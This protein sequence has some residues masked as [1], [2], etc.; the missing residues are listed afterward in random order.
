[1]TRTPLGK[2]IARAL[3]FC[4]ILQGWPLGA[5]P[6]PSRIFRSQG[7]AAAALTVFGPRDYVR[8]TGVPVVESA[9][10]RADPGGSF[11]LAIANGGADGQ[12]QRV[13]SAVI[14]LNGVIVVMPHEF[15]PGVGLIT[16]Q[17]PLEA[18]NTLL[19]E[20][21]GAPGSGLT[22]RI[23]GDASANQRPIASAGSD[24]TVNLGA[25]VQL[26]G[27]GSSD[28]D[29][30]PLTYRWTITS[31]PA[32]S[33][34]ALSDPTAVQ[35]T[36]VVDMPGAYSVALVV[37]DGSVDSAPDEVVVTTTNSAPIANAGTDQSVAVG[38]VVT[39]DGTGSQDADGDPLTYLWTLVSVPP[40]SAAALSDPTAVHPAFVADRSGTYTARLVVNDGHVDSAADSVAISTF[41][42]APVANA[43]ADQT[44]PVGTLVTL[45]G[46]GSHDVDGNA[47]TFHWALIS[48]PAG[49][50]AA[51]SD[52]S[53]VAPTFTIDRP[54]AYVA[55]LIVNDGTVDSAPDT[56]SI[57][58]VN[59]PPV[60][61]AGPDQS[62]FVGILVTL[63]GSGSSDVDGDPLTFHWSL[64][65]VPAGSAAALSAPSAVA[66][67]FVPDLPGTYVAQLTVND[68]T[69]ERS[70]TVVVS[71]RNSAPVAN[72]GADQSALVGETIT[73]DGSGSH[74]ADGDALTFQWSFLSRPA[75]S[76]AALS[77]PAAVH[78]TFDLDRF[79]T[80][81]VQLVVNDG[82]VDSAADTVTI[83][84]LNSPPIARA[85][86]DQTAPVGATVTLDG[87]GSS[88]V[89]GNALAFQW[90]LTS[91][92]AGSTAVL[93]DPAAVA[94]A[95]TI[96][97]P[98]TY[99]AQL[100]VNDGTVNSAPDTVSITTV[101]S[102]PVANAGLDRTALVGETVAL[103]GSA[104]HDVD[105]DMLTYFWS[106]TSRPI[107]SS[108]A[109]SDPSAVS[110][111][112]TI[113][114]SG[115][116]VVQLIV[117]D[118]FVDSAADT[119]VITTINSA[120]V[121]DAGPD[122]PVDVGATVTLD[123]TAS[124]DA[125]LNP[126]AYQWSL[127]VRPAGSAATLSDPSAPMPTFVADRAGTYVA[128]LIVNDGTLDSAP[129]TVMVVTNNHAPV[130]S[131]GANQ[132]VTQGATVVLDGS[133]S[134]DPDGDALTYLWSFDAR[135]AGSSAALVDPTAQNAVFV[136]DRAGDYVLR[137]VVNDGALDSAPSLVTVSAEAGV[138]VLESIA[139]TPATASTA[140][141][142]S[143]QFTA[144]G[145]WTDG[146]TEDVTATAV[147]QSADP[148]VAFVNAAGLADALDPGIV[149]IL[150][151]KDGIT[152]SATLTVTGPA[153]ASIVVTPASPIALVGDGVTFTA[154]GV[155]TDGTS[156]SLAGLVTWSSDSGAATINDATGAATAAAEGT[157]TIK[158]TRNGIE[159]SALLT[160]QPRIVDGTVPG[161]T[162]ASPA[163]NA[164]I[165]GPT[166]IV[167]TANDANFSKYVLDFAPV[168]SSAF[169]TIVTGTSPVINGT[170]GVFDPSVLVND[171]Y[172]VRL[173]VFD[174]GGNIVTT[175]RTFQVSQDVKVGN[176]TLSFQDVNVPMA[177]LPITV[178]RIYDSRDRRSGDFGVGWRLDVQ[179]LRVNTN[180]VLGTDWTGTRS[181]GLF[182][183]YCI[184][185]GTEQHKVGITLADGT[186]EEFDMTTSPSCA[187]LIPPQF[188]SASFV[189]RAGTLGTLQVLDGGIDLL[190]S[191]AFPGEMDLVELDS[192]LPFDPQTFQYTSPEGQ[193]F[194]FNK[195]AGVTSARDRYGNTL[196]FN[197]NGIVHSAGASVAFTRDAQKRITRITDPN[198]NVIN[199]TYDA[200]G[201][202]ASH[203]DALGNT[204]RFFYNL[205]HGLI[206]ARDPRGV[207]PLRNEYDD[208]GRLI[209]HVD[210][211]GNEIVYT[212]DLNARQ[213]IVRDRLGHQTVLEYDV[214]GNVVRTTDAAG[215]VVQRTYDA[216][217]NQLTEVNALGKTTRTSTY[218]SRNNR[219]T[220]KDAFGNQTTYTYN[221]RNQ[222]L[223]VA[224]PL[225]RIITNVYDASGNLLKSTD[226]LGKETTYTY[227]GQGLPLTMADGLGNLTTYEYDARGRVTKLTNPLGH[228]TS[229]TY[230][231]NGNRLTETRTRTTAAGVETLVTSF[232][233][234]KAGRL[235]KTT[236]P[237]N[238]TTQ[239]VY[240]SIGKQAETI[241]QLG[242]KTTY[243]YDAIG[244]L[245]RTTYPDNSIEEF[246]YDAEGRR[247]TT[248]DRAGRLT[249]LEYDALGRVIKTTSAGGAF[250]TTEYD[251]AGQP[252]KV[253]DERGNVTTHTYDDA[254]RRKTT[255]DALS[256]V[257]TF[258][259]D[260]AGNLTS[261]RDANNRETTFEYD[262]NN[263]RTKTIY[264]D[265]TF[266]Q[267]TYDAAGRTLSKRDQAGVTTLYEY[268][269]LGR[270][271][272][273]T[274]ALGQQTSYTYDEVGNRTS[275]TDANTNTT[276]F[277]YDGLGR[278]T[279]RT[280]PL[281]MSE[282]STYDA[283]GNLASRIDFNGKTTTY[284]YDALN[285][286]TAKV[287]DATIGGPAITF[288]YTPTGQ[289]ALM[290]DASGATSYTYDI[291]DRLIEK[292]TPQGTLTYTYDAAG[293]LAGIESSNS[294]GTSVG[295]SYDALNRLSGVTDHRSAAGVT[296]YTYDAV[297][298]L[299]AYAY[300][301]GVTHE[302]TYNTLN[303]LTELRV[304]NTTSTLAS[305]TYTLG[306]T[307]HRLSV[308][309]LGGR[310]VAYTYD[311]LYRLTSETI[312]GA[313]V[314]GTVG[315]QYDPVGN[316]LERTSTVGAVPAAAYSY[317]DN[318]RLQ[319]DT[320][321][322]NGNTT[323]SGGRLYRYDFENRLT[324]M[325]GDS[326]V[327]V[328]DGDGNRVAKTVA[329]VT[330][331]Y[332]VDDRN[333]TG[334]AQVLEEVA[335]GIVQRLY[336]YG[337]DLVSQMQPSGTSYYVYD[338]SG[339]TRHLS[340]DAGA[341]VAAYDY[342]AF[343]VVLRNDGAVSN[344]YLFRG[345][346]FD[347]NLELYF[348]RARYLD[349]KSGRFWTAD[350]FEGF[351]DEPLS[352]H[353]YL[354]ASA[355]SVNLSD[356][357]G[358]FSI[359]S[360]G[361]S[362]AIHGA[363][364]SLAI[365]VPLRALQVAMAVAEG[366]SLGA[367]V[368]EAAIG[369]ATDVAL[370]ALLGGVLSFAPRLVALRAVGQTVQR[371]ANSVWNLAPFAR[372]RAI[373][374]LLLR[375]APNV[376]R[377]PNFPII[378]SFW[379]GVATSIKSIDA[380]A[381]SYQ[382]GAALVS[383][384]AGY[385]RTL[386]NAGTLRQGALSINLA[387]ASRN[388][389]I[390]FE[391][392]A[393]TVQ[394]AQA[395]RAFMQTA[396]QQ[397]PNVRIVLTFIP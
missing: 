58:T 177:G 260:L 118:G 233:Y 210:A 94:P 350:T 167:G 154:T 391:Q 108:A 121:A 129:D 285:R 299:Q 388:L 351:H 361:V 279:R 62:A 148:A 130:A 254:G 370:G 362:M 201:D 170:L 29:G 249:Q 191:G 228:A 114:R 229:Y 330:T 211:L 113:D 171:I 161:G 212:N 125:D 96:D 142:E 166:P 14:T 303:R 168:G 246:T 338:G 13:T 47:L 347:G 37:N 273:V 188:V 128:Q 376:I 315:Y 42:S 52:P 53:V 82:H 369:L 33:G 314:S 152:G 373:E 4:L 92:P 181:S 134:S 65:S 318:D 284:T 333:P 245:A 222:A 67:Q 138:P 195:T 18:T 226:P 343:G 61:N 365:S 274:D 51:L 169:T 295:Y 345:E 319:S 112:F 30:D 380:A 7:V 352:L 120:P 172:T 378:D 275:Q 174:R 1:M 175:M 297:G 371:A 23:D 119:V 203:V 76:T 296:S 32:G 97:V 283:A 145:T 19:V 252:T 394:Q 236:Y 364:M 81:V 192:G 101:N 89:D 261:V 336:T 110:P 267:V 131:A 73:L 363:L 206:E 116:Y 75:G 139:V 337:L 290:I 262:A 217:G 199:Y 280:L 258:A 312:S 367:A 27:G 387:N 143:Q 256:H 109:L 355:D 132:S 348:L 215:G 277:E 135:P 3:I 207:R 100:I 235:T 38:S 239:T 268:D 223:T 357:S 9:T 286:L 5:P 50:G 271:I 317:D 99:V 288:S 2:G 294:G 46:S 186:V 173:R 200:N 381:A 117:N 237:D 102:P 255:T 103:D 115:V 80:Y 160:V 141:G 316:R 220:E 240:N 140:S 163:G 85:G 183:Q 68:G 25:Q 91:R 72:A 209:K 328:Y 298:N 45:D 282:I 111:A 104:S 146:H 332:L 187:Q 326:V 341:L 339:S 349:V 257:T 221:A 291:R 214:N 263:Q 123:G 95:F 323:A 105:G 324:N 382:S 325:N 159:G 156:Q 64:V 356:P 227:N 359:G 342:D 383:R 54:G 313:P 232:E 366:A 63:D 218:D 36:F 106:F 16:R 182:P 344:A 40:G 26:D 149:N 354:Y 309:E 247:L 59:S 300:P 205:S 307:G 70:D 194:V 322:S 266:D 269:D 331:R 6:T 198:G 179:T 124:H 238:S 231:A 93:S 304:T 74:D 321:D 358:E 41:N 11:V 43:G 122:Q 278:R 202:L 244:R 22:I 35:P 334:Y 241:D 385:A 390:A 216:R 306:S 250:T 133:G 158:A 86:A 340:D 292:A 308:A 374:A 360:V 204:T 12:H 329:G 71:T 24:Q 44:A 153:L 219:L 107:G 242:R 56:V 346:Y 98:G 184:T 243:L 66:P 21:R 213:Q 281:G 189:A 353:R 190:V 150:A 320:Y 395:L 293:N 176:F 90:S 265:G 392:G 251:L 60:A 224:D 193:V 151:T 180:R 397:F 57:N 165:T 327:I 137:L 287:P 234:D 185:H 264:P 368:Q 79:G 311:A 126:L 88:D 84:T 136:A 386:A 225:G 48:V 55:Q 34:A 305:F 208:A 49:S 301:N 302:Y 393:L 289:R 83:T 77:D 197:A 389:V 31:R 164:V 178:N 372:G 155:L 270:L 276:R 157:A 396:S 39:L 384:V 8:A 87:S 78:P 196:T 248:R 17:V 310:Q 230:D 147:W 272:T 20:L 335:G 10:F 375:G 69:A 377:T 127:T 379:Q 253:T 15:N 28:P 259:Y 144:T 162:F